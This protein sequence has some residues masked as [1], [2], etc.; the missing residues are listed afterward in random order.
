MEKKSITE[1]KAEAIR[2]SKKNPDSI[3]YVMDKKREHACCHRFEW[4]VR[5]KI[6]DGWHIVTRYKNGVELCAT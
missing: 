1:A 2:L 5:Q 3:Y 4:V 6:L